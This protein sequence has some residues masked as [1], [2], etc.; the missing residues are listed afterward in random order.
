MKGLFDSLINAFRLPELRKKLLFT[1]LILTIYM[2]GGNIPVPGIN[3]TVF[4]DIVRNWG[5]LGSMMDIISGGG[6]YSATIFAM[7]ITP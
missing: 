1:L 6:L 3:R 2:I 5:Q 4:S 7:G